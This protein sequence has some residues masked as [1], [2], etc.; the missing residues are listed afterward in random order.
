M[1]VQDKAVVISPT[2]FAIVLFSSD[3]KGAHNLS[4]RQKESKPADITMWA[5]EVPCSHGPEPKD[6]F[7]PD[8]LLLRFV[9]IIQLLL[10]G[11]EDCNMLYNDLFPLY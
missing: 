1:Q 6:F 3:R 4:E 5:K 9:T 10:P 11:L 7:S 8:S 2:H